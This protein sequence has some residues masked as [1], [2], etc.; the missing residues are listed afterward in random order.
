M[1]H[2][3][4]VNVRSFSKEAHFTSKLNSKVVPWECRKKNL[5][6]GDRKMYS[7]FVQL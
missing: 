1:F 4:L 7:Y 3:I 6:K 2:S 5:K